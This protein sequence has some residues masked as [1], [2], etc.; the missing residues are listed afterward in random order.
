MWLLGALAPPIKA[1]LAEQI[2]GADGAAW[3]VE[4][5]HKNCAASIWTGGTAV[6]WGVFAPACTHARTRNFTVS[7]SVF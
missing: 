3:R 4:K 1:F 6:R 2:K 7:T 5:A